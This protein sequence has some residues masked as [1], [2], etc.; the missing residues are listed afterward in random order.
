MLKYQ[1]RSFNL[2]HPPKL[3]FWL[4]KLDELHQPDLKISAY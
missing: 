4:K 2:E 1:L 3:T